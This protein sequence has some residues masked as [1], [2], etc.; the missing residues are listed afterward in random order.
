[1]IYLIDN[2]TIKEID[3][4][5]VE[6]C[7]L[8]H[9]PKNSLIIPSG[10][11]PNLKLLEQTDKH[12]I[13]DDC[14]NPSHLNK[15]LEY[16]RP[17]K[18]DYTIFT[19]DLKYYNRAH[20]N[21][22]VKFFPFWQY[23]I[24]KQQYTESDIKRTHKISSLNGTSWNHRKLVYLELSK[25][26]WFNDM[27]F[28][29][30]NR[31]PCNDWQNSLTDQEQTEFDLL[32]NPVNYVKQDV[33]NEIDLSIEHPAYRSSW[34]NLVVETSVKLDT[35]FLSEKTFKPIASGQLFLLVSAPGSISY[36][37]DVG[38]DVFDDIIDHSYD[39]VLDL[40]S[41]LKL[42]VKQLA[43]LNQLDVD[44]LGPTLTERFNNNSKFLVKLTVA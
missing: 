3:S 32:P 36:L 35:P 31:P 5:W 41:R 26:D 10:Q 30:G 2:D 19:G 8:R 12:L 20:F 44:Q 33:E 15:I 40:R 14:T 21:S 16:I 7:F 22:Q 42:I 11:Y 28:T 1:M 34:V 38:F 27:I 17:L 24:G 9:V 18:K 25:Q 13:F 37:R 23:W 39:N 29:F 4:T 43:R 6:Y